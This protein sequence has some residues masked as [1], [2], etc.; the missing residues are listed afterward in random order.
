M[1]ARWSAVVDADAIAAGKPHV[2]AGNPVD[3]GE[4]HA[5]LQAAAGAGLPGVAHPA[6]V[7]H[8]ARHAEVVVAGHIVQP[9]ALAK[10]IGDVGAGHIGLGHD[11]KRG[12]ERRQCDAFAGHAVAVP[13]P[14]QLGGPAI[15][16]PLGM[17]GRGL[18]DAPSSSSPPAQS[19]DCSTRTLNRC[20]SRYGNASVCATSKE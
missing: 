5:L 19:R 3:I 4:H 11:F 2:A 17:H 7:P 10:G 18:A 6:A 16:F 15:A 9:A 20:R 12:L 14:L 1:P 13:C 8:R